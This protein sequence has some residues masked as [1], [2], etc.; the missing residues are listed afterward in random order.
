M[1]NN[2]TKNLCSMSADIIVTTTARSNLHLIVLA[3]TVLWLACSPVDQ[4]VLVTGK[5]WKKKKK[6]AIKNCPWIPRLPSLQGKK[7]LVDTIKFETKKYNVPL[8]FCLFRVL[9]S[10]PAFPLK[11]KNHKCKA[12]AC[13]PSSWKKSLILEVSLCAKW[14]LSRLHTIFRPRLIH[15]SLPRL[16]FAQNI[17]HRGEERFWSQ[18]KPKPSSPERATT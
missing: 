14:I 4:V 18:Y 6:T 17:P 10:W 13:L 2:K 11:D 16:E 3:A 7:I 1:W 15:P 9:L 5:N 12:W 8:S